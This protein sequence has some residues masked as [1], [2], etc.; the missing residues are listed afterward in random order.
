MYNKKT[1]AKIEKKSAEVIAQYHEDLPKMSK[2]DAAYKA[3]CILYLSG[4]YFKKPET[5]KGWR[6]WHKWV[7]RCAIYWIGYEEQCFLWTF[8]KKNRKA[9]EKAKR[10]FKKV[11]A[12][13]ESTITNA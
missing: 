11:L 7:D 1:M 13:Y 10:Y 3:N 5:A 4:L 6:A 9:K 12:N 8:T 2:D